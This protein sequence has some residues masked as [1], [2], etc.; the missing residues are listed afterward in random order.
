MTAVPHDQFERNLGALR[1]VELSAGS[2]RYR[3]L[4]EGQ[5]LLFLGGLLLHSGFWRKVVPAFDWPIRAVVPDLPLGAHSVALRRS[6]DLTPTGIADLVAEFIEKLELKDVV[7]VANDTGGA[8]AQMLVNRHPKALAGLVLT[9]C[10]AF[11]NFL[12]P[13]FLPMQ[14]MAWLPGGVWLVS[15]VLRLRAVRSSPLGFGRL[16]VQ[17]LDHTV[18]DSYLEPARVNA[19]VRRDLGKVLRGIRKRYTVDASEEL[20]RFER[21]VLI[22]WP[23]KN[24][25]FPF[26]HA[27]RLAAIFPRA[28]LVEVHDS[29]AYV[30]EDQPATLARLI[31]RFLTEDCH[32]DEPNQTRPLAPSKTASASRSA[33]R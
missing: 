6:A 29:R 18:F 31:E 2:L 1:E 26:A 8:L 22:A 27:E 11:D 20:A 10:D 24:P 28:Q 7:V 4:G 30:P 19:G 3:D 21:P 9:P 32:P 25:H 15:Q 33:T 5:A 13:T 23:R 17:R 14:A 16:T 12:P